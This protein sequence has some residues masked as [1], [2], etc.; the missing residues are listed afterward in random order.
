[1]IIIDIFL[2]FLQPHIFRHVAQAFFTP[3]RGIRGS[4]TAITL[5]PIDFDIIQTKSLNKPDECEK[6]KTKMNIE[7]NE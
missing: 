5:H 6:R 3:F 1:M 7:N 4:L 2:G